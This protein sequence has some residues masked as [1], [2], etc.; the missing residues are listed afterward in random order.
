[1]FLY[2]HQKKH[3]IGLWKETA[4]ISNIHYCLTC[5]TICVDA[6]E[7]EM[8]L[9]F[10]QNRPCICCLA[11]GWM[12]CNLPPLITTVSNIIHIY[13]YIYIYI[14]THTYIYTHFINVIPVTL[15]H[16]SSTEWNQ[17]A[18]DNTLQNPV[19]QK[20]RWYTTYVI[21]W[22]FHGNYTKGRWALVLQNNIHKH[23]LFRFP[24]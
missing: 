19:S 13:I 15:P 5:N 10:A 22:G 23:T 11:G 21:N 20:H 4:C 6:Y 2:G 12:L 14:Y 18:G 1:M 8:C 7:Y 24:C 16:W 3:T 9:T 17:M